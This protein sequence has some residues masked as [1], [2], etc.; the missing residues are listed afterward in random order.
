MKKQNK[1]F[2]RT[3]EVMKKISFNGYSGIILN[4]GIFVFCFYQLETIGHIEWVPTLF[5]GVFTFLVLSFNID[6]D[7][8]LGKSPTIDT[9][10]LLGRKHLLLFIILGF[11]YEITRLIEKSFYLK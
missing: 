9:N 10:K 6:F 7:Y 8:V 1:G 3:L 5:G 4:I 11:L 2:E